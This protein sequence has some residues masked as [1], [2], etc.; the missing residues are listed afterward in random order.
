M[1]EP[2]TRAA[3]WLGEW[4]GCVVG[5]ECSMCSMETQ[6]WNARWV[7]Q[8]HVHAREGVG[9]LGAV[10]AVVCVAT[11]VDSCE[12]SAGSGARAMC[13]HTPRTL[14]IDKSF[15]PS[16]A[17][18]VCMSMCVG[19]SLFARGARFVCRAECQLSLSNNL[20]SM[21]RPEQAQCLLPRTRTHSQY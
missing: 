21:T 18:V 17:S 15:F 2:E 6:K 16:S 10:D 14:F 1:R 12:V 19:M 9:E 11:V 8:A 7:E 4:S 3:G 5:C 13:G 20:L